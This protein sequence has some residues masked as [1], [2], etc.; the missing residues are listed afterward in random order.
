MLITYSRPQD[1]DPQQ[2]DPAAPAADLDPAGYECE[3]ETVDEHCAVFG[4]LGDGPAEAV[5]IAWADEHGGADCSPGSL[6]P[7]RT[8]TTTVT[9]PQSASTGVAADRIAADVLSSFWGRLSAFI[10]DFG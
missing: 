4:Q 5:A 1:L 7:A 10:G 3:A 2:L 8:I 9:F 6:E